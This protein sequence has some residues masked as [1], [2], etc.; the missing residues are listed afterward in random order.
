LDS[1]LIANE[2]IDS[3]FRSGVLGLLCKLDLEK[4]YDNVNW[5]FLL[6]VAKKWFQGEMESLDSFLYFYSLLLCFD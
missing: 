2:C 5:E 4:A 1:I 6:C 3:C